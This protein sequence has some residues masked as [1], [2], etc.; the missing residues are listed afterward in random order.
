M[1]LHN[2]SVDLNPF[3]KEGKNQELLSILKNVIY[4]KPE[5][6]YFRIDE[7]SYIK[8]RFMNTTGG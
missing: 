4:T 6:H 3:L 5:K 2:N 8:K 1:D 7:K